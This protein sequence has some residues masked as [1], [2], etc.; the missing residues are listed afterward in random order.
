MYIIKGDSHFSIFER[1]VTSARLN[2]DHSLC[3]LIN[4]LICLIVY[5][6]DVSFK[7]I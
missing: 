5:I 7:V 6:I 4:M 3:L 1:V 2:I